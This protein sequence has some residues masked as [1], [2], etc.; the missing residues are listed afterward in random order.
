MTSS[1]CPCP[2]PCHTFDETS[3]LMTHG[4]AFR[5]EPGDVL[6]REGDL[7]H[8][9]VAVCTGHLLVALGRDLREAPLIELVTRGGMVGFSAAEPHSRRIHTV[10]AGS[11]GKAMR[12]DAD[13]LQGLLRRN[14]DAALA[15]ARA[16]LWAMRSQA[17]WRR[18]R[19]GGQAARRVASALLHL[20]DELGLADARGTFVPLH[21]TRS[22]L[23]RLIGCGDATVTRRITAWSDLVHTTREGIVLHD[24]AGLEAVL[25][26]PGR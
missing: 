10:V 19:E 12:L 7:A 5:F 14:K 4:T 26:R 2:H 1:S 22:E 24:R 9:L 15:L 11:A 25:D 17:T 3:V 21:L 23:G 20:A 16:Q 6:W 13:D 8:E 18:I